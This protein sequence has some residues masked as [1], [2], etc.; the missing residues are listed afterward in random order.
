[1]ESYIPLE[2]FQEALKNEGGNY[3][4]SLPGDIAFANTIKEEKLKLK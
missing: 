4:M 2:K 3:S 1:M